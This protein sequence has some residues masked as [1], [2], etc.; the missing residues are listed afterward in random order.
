MPSA[1]YDKIYQELRRRIEEEIYGYQDLLPSENMLTE[2]FE[3]SR[4]TVRRAIG[5]LAAEGYVQSLSL[6][7]ISP[8]LSLSE[9]L[10]PVWEE[11]SGIRFPAVLMFIRPCG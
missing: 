5:Q 7:H 8:R 4:N 3:S 2:Q 1:K 11:Q 10:L 6:I 9:E